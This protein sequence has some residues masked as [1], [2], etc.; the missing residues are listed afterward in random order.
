MDFVL[1][2]P[3]TQR[4]VDSI[5]VVIDRYSKMTHFIPRKKTLDVIHI[6]VLFFREIIRLYGVPKS[7]TS[8]RDSKFLSHFWV[9]LWKLFESSLKFSSTAHRR[10]MGRQRSQIEL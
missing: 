10:Q 6:A 5:F 2:L 3:R 4:G 8:D 9:T 1:G 7:I